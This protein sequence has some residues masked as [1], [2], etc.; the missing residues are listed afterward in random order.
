M[1]RIKILQ[2]DTGP[3]CNEDAGSVEFFVQECSTYGRVRPQIFS[4]NVLQLQ[5]VTWHL[6]S[7]IL[8]Y[9]N[10]SGIIR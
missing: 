6:L 10:E 3:S 4:A 5:R 7:E 9:L 1:F 2:Y 8:Q